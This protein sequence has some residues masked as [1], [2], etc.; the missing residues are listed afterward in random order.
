[1]IYDVYGIKSFQTHLPQIARQIEAVG[2][3]YLVTNRN[4]PAMVAIPFADYQ[5]IEDILIELNSPALKKDIAAGRLEYQQG[6]TKSLD[7]VTKNHE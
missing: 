3:H 6:K 4:K 2:G 5:A 1:M 7:E